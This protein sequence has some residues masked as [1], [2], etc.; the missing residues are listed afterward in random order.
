M[1]QW[2][3][4]STLLLEN[5]ANIRSETIRE[6]SYSGDEEILPL[7]AAIFERNPLLDWKSE[8]GGVKY[9]GLSILQLLLEQEPSP[10]R[11]LAIEHLLDVSQTVGRGTGLHPRSDREIK[12]LF[13]RTIPDDKD[14]KSITARLSSYPIANQ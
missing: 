8:F 4:L 5:G 2:R 11:F 13:L 6:E 10:S 7:E 9:E 1:R 14:R 3:E 12:A